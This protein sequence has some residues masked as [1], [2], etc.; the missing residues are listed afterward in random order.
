MI[1]S[2]RMRINV[3][4]VAIAAS[5]LTLGVASGETARSLWWVYAAISGLLSSINLLIAHYGEDR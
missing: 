3:L 1:Q 2:A 5:Y 4:L